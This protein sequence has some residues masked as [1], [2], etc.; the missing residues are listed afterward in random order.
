[1]TLSVPLGRAPAGRGCRKP[2]LGASASISALRASIPHACALR[3]P[4]LS[5][6]DHLPSVRADNQAELDPKLTGF[7]PFESSSFK[8]STVGV[9]QSSCVIQSSVVPG[10]RQ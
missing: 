8:E 6:R 3:L 9:H 5:S 10:C 2:S 4:C 7:Y 1:M